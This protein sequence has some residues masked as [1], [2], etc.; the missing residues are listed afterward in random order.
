[1]SDLRNYVMARCLW[2]P[3]RDSWKDAMEF[4]R[5]HYAEASG[6][7]IAYLTDYHRL[8]ARSGLH[9]TCFSTESALRLDGPTT[10]M[11]W[12]RFAEAK[13]LARTDEVRLRV[14]KASLCAY[15]A[16]LSLASGD[17]NLEGGMCRPAV[18]EFGPGLLA[19]YAEMCARHGA[20]ME[21]ETVPTG[22]FIETLRALYGG[23]PTVRVENDLWRVTA[24]PTSNGKI[25]EMVHK[26]TGRNVIRPHRAFNRFRYEDWVREGDGPGAR[27]VLGYAVASASREAVS[28]A[29]TTPDGTRFERTIRLVGDA[30][31]IEGAVT[32]AKARP[33]DLWLHP[34]YDAASDKGDPAI[35]GVYVRAPGWVQANRGWRSGRSDPGGEALI[36][37]A[38]SG[39]EFALYNHRER[40]GVVQRFDPLQIGRL[41]LYWS[42]SRLQV[43]LEMTPK[44]TSLRSGETTR[45]WYEVRYLDAPPD[46]R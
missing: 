27:S 4:C 21:S 38:A 6:P 41:G 10:R 12:D 29:L 16:A 31:R 40:F 36:A 23:L 45:Y 43:N 13:A 34:E 46:A 7:I 25:V 2:K 26:A 22:A 33:L 14:E 3:G 24:L 44:V 9:P 30:V 18:G 1:M 17:L 20:T 28:M 15:R 5:L 8:L 19:T 37:G 11:V 35:V 42:P 39:G 32:A